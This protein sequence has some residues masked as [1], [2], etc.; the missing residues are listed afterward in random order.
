MLAWAVASLTATG[1]TILDP[2]ALSDRDRRFPIEAARAAPADAGAAPP[3][4]A[5]GPITGACEEPPADLN[6]YAGTLAR[7]MWETDLERRALT[8]QALERSRLNSAFNALTWPAVSFAA[9]KQLRDPGWSPRDAVA[10]G[11]AAYKVLGEGIPERDRIY[12]LAA[13]RLACSLMAAE[14]Y[15][16]LRTPEVSGSQRWFALEALTRRLEADLAGHETA[17]GSTVIALEVVSSPVVPTRSPVHA[18]RLEAIGSRS[19]GGSAD[20]V[21][22]FLRTISRTFDEGIETRRL[23]WETAADVLDAGNLLRYRSSRIQSAMF[24]ELQGRAPAPADP[25]VAARAM[26]DVVTEAAGRAASAAQ[27]GAGAARSQSGDGVPDLPWEP[28]PTRL[29][30]LGKKG[31]EAVQSFWNM[32]ELPLRDARRETRD[33]L[34][35]HQRRVASYRTEAARLGC[36][37]EDISAFI[38]QLA[39]RAALPSAGSASAPGGGESALPASGRG[40]R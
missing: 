27:A 38:A 9:A 7:A 36:G 8:R 34:G 24:S 6:A 30:G 2:M 16:Y 19:G 13:N 5:S 23:A 4:C 22:P 1:C 14:A 20:P 40:A 10:L 29:K 15:L 11:F 39:V 3:T 17:R 35:V 31:L 12:L 37:E 25:L 21:T 18:A 32:R 33:W 28:T 26:V